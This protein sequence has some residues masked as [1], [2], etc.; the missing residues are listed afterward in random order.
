MHNV[1]TA[2]LRVQNDI[3]SAMDHGRVTGLVPLGFRS[4]FDTVFDAADHAVLLDWVTADC[5]SWDSSTVASV[6]PLQ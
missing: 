3:L 4:A 2:L 1:E 5:H 6:L